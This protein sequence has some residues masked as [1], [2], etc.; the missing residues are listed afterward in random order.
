MRTYTP[1][2]DTLPVHV[3]VVVQPARL[4]KL[5]ERKLSTNNVANSFATK[6]IASKGN[7][8]SIECCSNEIVPDNAPKKQRH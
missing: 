2:A 5:Q 8:L 1:L 3:P 4:T 7:A 6:E